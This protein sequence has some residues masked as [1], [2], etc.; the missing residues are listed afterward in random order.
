MNKTTT[1]STTTRSTTTRSTGT[2]I[3]FSSSDQPRQGPLL[4]QRLLN[5]YRGLGDHRV[6]GIG[7]IFQDERDKIFDEAAR[8]LLK[9]KVGASESKNTNYESSGT[10]EHAAEFCGSR[11]GVDA[12]CGV[13]R[14]GRENDLD[15]CGVQVSWI[16]VSD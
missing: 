16:E 14:Q 15:G 1:R 10:E 2:G 5:S 9:L 6:R 4:R 13:L 7:I 11:T 8:A 3:I 12:K